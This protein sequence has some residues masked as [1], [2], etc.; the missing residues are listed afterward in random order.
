V[1][2]QYEDRGVVAEIAAAGVE[3]RGGQAS[4]GFSRMQRAGLVNDRGQ[5]DGRGTTL[6]HS[7]SEQDQ[8]V[9]WTQF[10]FL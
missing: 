10:Q 5:V 1:P 2:I 4:D 7:V 3:H 8:A 9:V 6:L